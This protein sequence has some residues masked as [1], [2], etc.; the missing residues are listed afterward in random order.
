MANCVLHCGIC[1]FRSYGVRK[2]FERTSLG[3]GLMR[4]TVRI[5][6]GD[7]LLNEMTMWTREWTM[8]T[9]S[10]NLIT[11]NVTEVRVL[12]RRGV[13]SDVSDSNWTY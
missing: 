5:R 3:S 6:G 12:M 10:Y 9:N 4:L 13:E 7:V 2:C 11:E 8:E 1:R